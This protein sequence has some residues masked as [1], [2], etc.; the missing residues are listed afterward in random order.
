MISDSEKWAITRDGDGGNYAP[1]DSGDLC[2]PDCGYR[3][4]YES[5]QRSLSEMARNH[6][7]VLDEH[8]S[9]RA[10]IVSMMKRLFG[11]EVQEVERK[12]GMR[13]ADADDEALIMY[14][15]GFVADYINR[16]RSNRA[17]LDTLRA[18]LAQQGYEIPA[19]HDLTAWAGAVA[20]QRRGVGDGFPATSELT[21]QPL[22]DIDQALRGMLE[23]EGMRVSAEPEAPA[24]SDPYASPPMGAATQ[25]GGVPGGAIE[26]DAFLDASSAEPV[27][28][29]AGERPEA[30]S[31]TDKVISIDDESF[32]GL[33]DDLASL[34]PE[35]GDDL[36]EETGGVVVDIDDMLGDANII[37]IGEEMG[38]SL[39]IPLM[40]DALDWVDTGES[41]EAGDGVGEAVD[42]ASDT[43]TEAE[44]MDG[45]TAKPG[46]GE[47][48][49]GSEAAGDVEMA[50]GLEAG[51]DSGLG[52]QAGKAV[53]GAEDDDASVPDGYVPPDVS[54]AGVV[55]SDDT[56]TSGSIG[57]ES[58]GGEGNT[59]AAHEFVPPPVARVKR[60][61]EE[62][63]VT[64][65]PVPRRQA[66]EPTQ[67]PAADADADLSMLF[68]DPDVPDDAQPPGAGAG[69]DLAD[70]FG[71]GGQIT[72]GTAEI[73]GDAAARQDD[74]DLADLF[75]GDV[76]VSAGSESEGGDVNDDEVNPPQIP[77]PRKRAESHGV[78]ADVVDG[79]A[80]Q[81]TRRSGEGAEA[82]RG[83]EN[84]NVVSAA[85]DLANKAVEWPSGERL[86]ATVEL[87]VPDGM[88]PTGL[89]DLAA[90]FGGESAGG[91]D[92]PN[93]ESEEPG[94]A[95]GVGD[96]EAESVNRVKPAY[97]TPDDLGTSRMKPDLMVAAMHSS[98][99]GNKNPRR[100]KKKEKPEKPQA[101]QSRIRA[102]RSESI[103]FDV[104]ALAETATVSGEGLTEQLTEALIAAVEVPRPVFVSTLGRIADSPELAEAWE[105]HMR[106]VDNPP[107]RFL[108]PRRHH[109]AMG[110]LAIPYRYRKHAPADFQHSWWGEI[111]DTHKGIALYELAVLLDAI[112]DDVVGYTVGED[113]VQLRVNL[114]HGLTGIIVVC[115]DALAAGERTREAIAQALE[116]LQKERLATLLVLPIRRSRLDAVT[117]LLREEG[118]QRKWD[119]PM[120]VAVTS[121]PDYARDR[122]ASAQLALGSV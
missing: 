8:Q 31:P 119:P 71:D 58:A 53:T 68:S 25:D 10:G 81:A 28:A 2:G 16:G 42:V 35:I 60:P 97:L 98:Q 33:D 6:A 43:S 122:G 29:A 12:G 120:P 73:A 80:E 103:Q 64:A 67:V 9:L 91:G 13:L 96:A 116:S 72:G 101:P 37:D 5:G 23:A 46:G 69:G 121:S 78:T 85:G 49:D 45:G 65:P 44:P 34:I 11:G 110:S 48:G 66:Q 102:Q 87:D 77:V 86:D 57:G 15:E 41:V 27:G 106:S 54:A 32:G 63:G 47:P 7:K 107:V 40:D 61:G 51:S 38:D 76:H 84:E 30:E 19:G 104:P 88:D 109:K 62:R 18:V 17:G 21:S 113:V 24:E 83:N 112:G 90:L 59:A 26:V 108:S 4:L 14:L 100:T 74:A 50:G 36:D 117:A 75:G 92:G 89:A 82:I 70:L 115:G 39:D 105:T 99:Q 94:V 114:V 93:D 1:V 55:G 56:A 52:E 111:L 20:Q 118:T 79:V 95:A 22:D 3:G